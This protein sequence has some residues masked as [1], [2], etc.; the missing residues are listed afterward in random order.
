MSHSRLDA[1]GMAAPGERSGSSGSY[2]VSRPGGGRPG[3][4]T[5]PFDGMHAAGMR[6]GQGAESGSRKGLQAML[7]AP[8]WAPKQAA[9]VCRSVDGDDVKHSNKG[10]GKRTTSRERVGEGKDEMR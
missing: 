9:T 5:V 1:G 4:G 8:S 10:V 3:R 7:I 2:V 6:D